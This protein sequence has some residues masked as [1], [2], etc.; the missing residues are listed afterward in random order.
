VLGEAC[1]IE[2]LVV[3]GW[4]LGVAVEAKLGLE[5]LVVPSGMDEI[6]DKLAGC[7]VAVDAPPAGV[8]LDKYL[9]A[10]T[11]ELYGALLTPDCR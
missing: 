9:A 6:A 5:L 11:L 8:V 10:Q 2:E 4:A 1:A 3:M 7:V